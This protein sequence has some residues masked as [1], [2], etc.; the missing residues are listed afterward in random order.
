MKNIYLI[1]SA[2]SED[3]SQGLSDFERTLR[4]KGIEDINTIGSYLAL[5]SISPDM[6]LSSCALRAQETTV[7]LAK[8]LDFEGVKYFL[9]ELYSSSYKDILSIIMAQDD[10]CSSIFVVG[11]SPQLVELTNWFCNE[12]IG[13]LPS[14][15]VISLSF[16]IN[17][18]SEIESKKAKMEFFIYPKQFKYYMPKQ[19]RDT[20]PR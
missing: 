14:M 4:E 12:N 11:H 8:K 9:E 19:I 13:K 17:E 10:E 3:F 18:W 7:E 2:K 1:R 16:D 15:G 20:L 6:I 5:Q